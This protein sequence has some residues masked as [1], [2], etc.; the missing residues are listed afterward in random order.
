MTPSKRLSQGVLHKLVTADAMERGIAPQRVK[1]WVAAAA[2]FELLNTAVQDGRIEAYLIKGGFAVELRQ[3]GAARTSEDIDLVI[4]GKVNGVELLREL[5][6]A[7]WDSFRFV[8]KGE[9]AGDHAVRVD[10][11]VYF[12]TVIWCTLN[13]DV[14]DEEMR[15]ID[16]VENIDI[17]RYALPGVRPVACLSRSH[18]LAEWIHCT[19]RPALDGKR[20]N[21]ARNVI[22]IYLLVQYAGSDE[23]N[24]VAACKDVFA[25]EATH[26][27]PPTPDFPRQWLPDISGLL[28]ELGLDVTLEDLVRIVT[29]Y[30]T[31]L[32]NVEAKID[33]LDLFRERVF[34]QVADEIGPPGSEYNFEAG[35]WKRGVLTITL[36]ENAG[37]PYVACVASP[38][39]PL[40]H[41]SQAFP[42]T[43]DESGAG[44]AAALIADRLQ[45]PYWQ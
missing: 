1:R 24:V 18:Q 19:T 28:L 11:Q 9:R 36:G 23:Q 37:V 40:G 32:T 26:S 44:Q 20:K 13:V 8:I 39:G 31:G 4:R 17:K 35:S 45:N 2:F 14:L 21:R 10:L 41:R 33:T 15:E 38:N 16:Y 27:W 3:Q 22:D 12:N 6:P 42:F 5:L 34:R 29:E 25:R 43:F 30:V 7:E